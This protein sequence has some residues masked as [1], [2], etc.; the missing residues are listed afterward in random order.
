MCET[1]IIVQMSNTN[2]QHKLNSHTFTEIASNIVLPK[3]NQAMV[4]NFINYIKQIKHVTVTSKV[5]LTI[6]MQY[7]SQIL[8]I[9]SQ[10]VKENLL[11]THSS[12]FIN[13]IEIPIRRLINT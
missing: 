7:V 10:T 4:F 11:K 3:M 1:P 8:L 13:E 5:V 9:N 6:N 12:I 2:T